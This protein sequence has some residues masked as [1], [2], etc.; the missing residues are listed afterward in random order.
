MNLE[1]MQL[2]VQ[3]AEQG[4]FTGAAEYCGIPKSTL[5][6]RVSNLETALDVRLLRRTTRQLLLTELGEEFYQRAVKILREV[7]DTEHELKQRK[8]R[9]SGRVRVFSPVI[10]NS[11]F[12]GEITEYCK[13]F[14]DI[15]LGLHALEANPKAVQERRFDVLL[16]PG[17]LEDSTLIAKPVGQMHSS[18]FAAPSY[19][20]SRGVPS[21]P[22]Q[23]ESHDC[24]YLPQQNIEST[25]WH[26]PESDEAGRNHWFE[27][28]PKF[29]VDSPELATELTRAGLG[30][31]QLPRMLAGPL[32]TQG[33]LEPVFPG[34]YEIATIIYAAYHDRKLLPE[35]V[36]LTIDFMEETLQ[37]KVE[38]LESGID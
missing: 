35:K 5:S 25:R 1:D 28:T 12:T 3:V 38:R 10:F 33:A 17:E 8:T 6:R 27:I 19:L 18:Y 9:V 37:K 36:R 13:R 16:H 34:R 32:V 15:I 26:F 11:L 23:L 4:S 20:A 2:F 29:I 31:A 21:H 14:P 7:E 30:I 22:A 24:I